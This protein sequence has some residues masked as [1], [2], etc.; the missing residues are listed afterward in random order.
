MADAA[1]GAAGPSAASG[2]AKKPK[3]AKP[4]SEKK[5]SGPVEPAARTAGEAAV[6]ALLKSEDT[7]TQARVQ[8]MVDSGDAQFKLDVMAAINLL[9]SEMRLVFMTKGETVY[10]AL[11]EYSKAVKFQ[12]LGAE[13][14][15]AYSLI[16]RSSNKGIWSR[17]LKKM[18]M[19]QS[20]VTGASVD[21]TLK[22]L[23]QRQLIKCEKS[24]ASKNKKVYMLFELEPA[25]EVKGRCWYNGHEF[26]QAFFARL[27]DACLSVIDRS[28]SAS[29]VAVTQEV[30]MKGGFGVLVSEDDVMDLLNGQVYQGT[31]EK[32]PM[33]PGTYTPPGADERHLVHYRRRPDHPWQSALCDIPCTGCPVRF[34]CSETEIG[35][36]HV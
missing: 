34:Q 16:E 13:D 12:G 8:E 28:G 24:I 15:A 21:K 1:A 19:S 26:D 9:S 11:R 33:P 3:K 27:T 14:M 36:A 22:H 31:L 4:A 18:M 30:M 10:Y 6:L 2:A 35:R 29:V 5:P 25:L 20:H 7:V 23:M 17:D 32:L